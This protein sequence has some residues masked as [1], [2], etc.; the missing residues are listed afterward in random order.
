MGGPMPSLASARSDWTACAR[1][2]AVECRS[3]DRP[4]SLSTVTGSTTSPSPRTW[5]RSRSW[6]LTRATTTARSPS[7]RSPAVVC[8]ATDRSLPATV[9][10]ICADT[11]GAPRSAGT[12]RRATGREWRR[13]CGSSKGIERLRAPATRFGRARAGRPANPA[14]LCG[15]ARRLVPGGTRRGPPGTRRQLVEP[16]AGHA[17]G[18]QS[19]EQLAALGLDARAAMAIA[20][21]AEA[22][23]MLALHDGAPAEARRALGMRSARVAGGVAVVMGRDPTGGYW[24]KALG[25]GVT[26]PVTEELVADLVELYAS[27]GAPSLCLQI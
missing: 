10:V 21:T 3:T 23:F 17:R 1:T 9:T 4:S 27:A 26:E 7:K 20:E 15:E 14:L 5:N 25:F 13:C 12:R 24:N 16:T 22:E 18:G 19:G 2:C 11:V 6:P 8:S